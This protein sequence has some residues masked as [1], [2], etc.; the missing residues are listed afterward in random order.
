M[1]PGVGRALR[2]LVV[3]VFLAVGVV[4]F[5]TLNP[6]AQVQE[7]H[8]QGGELRVRDALNVAGTEPIGVRGYVFEG[9]GYGLRVCDA[10][11]RGNPPRC[12][13]P[14]FDLYGVEPERFDLEEG[15]DRTGLPVRWTKDSVAVYGSVLGTRMDVTQVLR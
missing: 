8:S 2:V 1:S 7:P 6:P 11:H 4:A 14:Y 5:R 13:A 15:T 3:L 9:G 10:R 12:R